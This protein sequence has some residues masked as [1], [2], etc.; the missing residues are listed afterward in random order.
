MGMLERFASRMNLMSEMF[1]RTG[2]MGGQNI[3]DASVAGLHQAVFR[4]AKCNSV[5]ECEKFL[6]VSD[7]AIE[8]QDFC[9]NSKLIANLREG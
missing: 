7:G 4:C 9:P 6:A 1:S 3:D 5:E 8:P 2:A